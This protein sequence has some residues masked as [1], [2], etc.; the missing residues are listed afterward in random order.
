L[1]LFGCATSSAAVI[2][3]SQL[4]LASIRSPK[5]QQFSWVGIIRIYQWGVQQ[6]GLAR[7]DSYFDKLMRDLTTLPYIL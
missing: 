4:R 7:A 6:Y 3:L 1:L 5:Y 2:G